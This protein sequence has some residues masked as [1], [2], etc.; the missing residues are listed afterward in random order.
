[1]LPLATDQEPTPSE[2]EAGREGNVK[3][4]AEWWPTDILPLLWFHPTHKEE[5]WFGTV[6]SFKQP[7]QDFSYAEF[8]MNPVVSTFHS[9][10]WMNLKH[11]SIWHFG[12]CILIFFEHIM[13]TSNLPARKDAPCQF[14]NKKKSL[15]YAFEMGLTFHPKKHRLYSLCS[16]S[17]KHRIQH[18][19]SFHPLR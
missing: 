18:R 17:H 15:M 19:L 2:S 4:L 16:N 1:M 5:N 7:F 14:E 12:Q 3:H 11:K 9:L 6:L 8:S 10:F 13:L